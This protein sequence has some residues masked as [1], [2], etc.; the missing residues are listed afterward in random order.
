MPELN[1][2]VRASW[3]VR[4]C[5]SIASREKGFHFVV[6]HLFPPIRIE[7]FDL[8]AKRSK[9]RRFLAGGLCC[10]HKVHDWH[11]PAADGHWLSPLDRFDQFRQ[12]L[13]GI[14]HVESHILFSPM[15]I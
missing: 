7:H 11:A 9:L 1:P 12:S 3:G 5:N 6:R 8:A 15:F 13:P 4:L 14:G 2:N 10:P